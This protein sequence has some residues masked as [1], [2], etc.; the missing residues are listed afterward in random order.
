MNEDTVTY[1]GDGSYSALVDKSIR[2]KGVINM[3]QKQSF[4]K[5]DIT[6]KGIVDNDSVGN[7]VSINSDL[8]DLS[9]HNIK[10]VVEQKQT[11]NERI[12][13][14]LENSSDTDWDGNGESYD[15]LNKS[16]ASNELEKLFYQEQID[17]L[18]ELKEQNETDYED[19][20][21]FIQIKLEQLQS[22]LNE[23]K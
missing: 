5:G 2:F 19:T 17:L 13:I 18:N 7:H 15:Y 4:K 14:I 23:L 11:L 21:K 12:F 20:W 1:M 3:K 6:N 8:Y 10:L 9:K 22:K 16:K